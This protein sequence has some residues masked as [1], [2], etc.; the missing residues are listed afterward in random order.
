MCAS[1]G[2]DGRYYAKNINIQ[3]IGQLEIEQQPRQESGSKVT[4]QPFMV[5]RSTIP[6][7]CTPLLHIL[8]TKLGRGSDN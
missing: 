5:M 2:V 4:E 3:R 6:A 1:G 8:T 7:S